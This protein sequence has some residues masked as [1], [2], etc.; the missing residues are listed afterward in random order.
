MC[1]FNL[2]NF[3]QILKKLS[4][5]KIQYI[6]KDKSQPL[7]HQIKFSDRSG[8]PLSIRANRE[9]YKSSF[10]PSVMR[11]LQDSYKR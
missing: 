9:R 2:E 1:N 4:T 3:D 7:F 8:R 10:L 5:N 11:L 6:L